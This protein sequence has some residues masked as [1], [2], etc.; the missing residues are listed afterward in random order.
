MLG[1]TNTDTHMNRRHILQQLRK[2]EIGFKGCL[3]SAAHIPRQMHKR[4]SKENDK[5]PD[6]VLSLSN[7]LA[8]RDLVTCL[9]SVKNAASELAD[10]SGPTEQREGVV[11]NTPQRDC[12]LLFGGPH[13]LVN[14]LQVMMRIEWMGLTFS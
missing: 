14:I 12:F 11:P 3:K 7:A 10:N 1:S 9:A 13:V 6:S 5:I 2:R 4:L 8:A